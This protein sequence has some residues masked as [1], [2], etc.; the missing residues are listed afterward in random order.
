MASEIRVNKINSRTGVGTITLSPTGVDFTGIATVATLKATTGIVTTL[1]ATGNATVGG[2]LGV[3]GETTFSTHINLGDSDRLRLGADNDLQIFHNGSQNLI[4]S[5][6]GQ[7]L[8][9]RADTFQVTNSGGTENLLQAI[10]D[11][12]VNLYHNGTKKFETTGVGASVTGTFNVG[13]GTSI[14]SSSL[15]VNDIQ[16]PTTGPLSNRNLVINGAMRVAQ[17][18]TSSTSTGYLIDRFNVA[19]GQASITQSQQALSSGSPYD[20]GF[21]YFHRSAVTSTSSANNA[22]L[23]LEQRIEAQN[24]AGSGWKYKDSSTNIIA[25]FWARS[26]LA[27]TYYV[28]YRA[29]DSAS[30]LFYINKSFTLVADTWT[31]VEHVIPGHSSLV[32]NDD[33]GVGLQITIVPHYGTTYTNNNIAVGSWFTRSTDS[34]FPDYAQ[35]FTNTSSAT[36]DVTG[37]QLEVGS[38]ATPFEH[39]SYGD[40]L[41]R[42][43]RYFYRIGGDSV[44]TALGIGA[45][46]SGTQ[47][48]V[49]LDLPC[50]MRTKPSASTTGASNWLYVAQGASSQARNSTPSI[51]DGGDINLTTLRLFIESLSGLTT[52]YAVWCLVNAN[53][54]L[55][56][57][58]EL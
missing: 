14:T 32:F 43:Q 26:S 4:L 58:A 24:L 3:T 25:S 12:A 1:S 20:E 35:N 13:T 2:T 56:F 15:I 11:G 50:A 19:S 17:R 37:L 55:D 51:G 31:K 8:E 57:S 47:I 29:L 28:Q 39:R 54:S 9:T 41:A 45:V 21:R 53:H 40:E 49:H 10:G 34:Y 16:Y 30:G 6:S 52:G 46:Y 27:G 42:C 23:Q 38:K 5:V 48:N 7:V 18:G 33:T 22:Y 44:D 36:F